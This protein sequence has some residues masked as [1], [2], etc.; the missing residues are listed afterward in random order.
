MLEIRGELLAGL[1]DPQKV[2]RHIHSVT[3][4]GRCGKNNFCPVI[5]SGLGED[6]IK[7]PI[8]GGVWKIFGEAILAGMRR[9]V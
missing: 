5:E 8:F 4:Q 3:W 2:T 1:C 6:L 9:W 7:N